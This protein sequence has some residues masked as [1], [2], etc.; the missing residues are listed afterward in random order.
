VSF[1]K[2]IVHLKLLSIFSKK[3][4]INL[5]IESP[6]M[7]LNENLFKK[8]KSKK[9][10]QF[11]IEQIK[12]KNGK[13]SFS[14]N[15]V[16]FRINNLNL[17][18]VRNKDK[19]V[20]YLKAPFLE[21]TLPIEKEYVK[22]H[23]RLSGKLFQQ[24]E[25]I[26][27][28][29][30]YWKTDNFNIKLS[31]NMS[32]KKDIALTAIFSGNPE[33]ILY[34]L[35]KDFNIS[36]FLS[37]RI[38]IIKHYKKKLN[39]K[40]IFKSK[41]FHI[42][43]EN[44]TDLKGQGEWNNKDKKI[45]LKAYLHSSRLRSFMTVN[46]EY[47]K[48]IIKGNNFSAK[49]ACKLISIHD[50]VPLNGIIDTGSIE[51]NKKNVSGEVLIKEYKKKNY[52]NEKEFNTDGLID[53]NYNKETKI[54]KFS[55]QRL[56]TEF[57]E[58]AINGM[59][60]SAKKSMT[61]KA[62]AKISNMSAINKYSV[63]FIDLNLS[64]WHL[65]Q[66]TGYFSL[67][68]EKSK[69]KTIFDSQFLGKDFF[70]NGTTIDSLSLNIIKKGEPI[71]GTILIKDRKL[72]TK[73]NII[74]NK[75]KTNINFLNVKGKSEK[76]FK[77]LNIP[78]PTAGE[79]YGT[80]TYSQLNGGKQPFVK[81]HLN[82]KKLYLST[83]QFN[84]VSCDFESDVDSLKLNNIDFVFK[85]GKGKAN[86]FFDF[87][88]LEYEI[89]GK[90]S[91]VNLNKIYNEITGKGEIYFDG[92]GKF[93]INPIIV[94]YRF[95]N[96]SF[97]HNR[98]FSFEGQ[99][100]VFTNFEDFSLTTSGKIHNTNHKSNFL[101]ELKKHQEQYSGNYNFNL[102]DIDLLIPWE[103]NIGVIAI[104]GYFNSNAKNK[105]INTGIANFSGK[106]LVLPSFSHAIENY[107][108]FI[109]FDNNNFTLESLKG[110]IG[111]GAV[112]LNGNVH[113]NDDGIQNAQL[114]LTGSRMLIFPMN[115]TQFNMDADISLKYNNKGLSLSGNMNI[116]SGI[117]ER[118]T[119]EGISFYTS[120]NFSPE[121]AD[122]IKNMK[123]N[124]KLTGKK[125]IQMNNSFGSVTG[126]FDLSI[127]GTPDSPVIL[128]AIEG[129]TGE[130]YFS[131]SKFKLLK[132]KI[133]FNNKLENNPEIII[134]SEAFI[135]NYRIK[136][137][138]NGTS[139]SPILEFKS[140]PSL[141][142]QEIFALI[143]LGELFEKQKSIEFSSQIGSTYLLSNALMDKIQKRAKK[144]GIDL[145]RIDTR[146]SEFTTDNSPRITVGTTVL[147][148]VLIVYSTNIAG[149]RREVVYFQ[150]QLS[151]A[152]S[153]IGMRNE[154]G[155]FSVDI[156]FR[157][158][159]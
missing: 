147:K 11:N 42:G 144:F 77:I 145:L 124:L 126:G 123:L 156:R 81:G 134:K 21:I 129:K 44:F 3:K 43:Q 61:I 127:K 70:T 91:S 136:F 48:V 82:S 30:A 22:F 40:A 64:R 32:N 155:R 153:L 63:F 141:P 76:I 17:R 57:G 54:T 80:C 83:F 38:S 109:T 101:F 31:G 68:L 12:I 140:S 120:S 39:I 132:A 142:T 67:N 16:S 41:Y 69:S 106:T 102:S 107:S 4:K 73:A 2:V 46:T 5:V 135:K 104:N 97:Y 75:G 138:I 49:K 100:K 18:S 55:S 13:L 27:I 117:W 6:E 24:N 114:N 119:T 74:I 53:F 58:L 86:I 20:Y 112:E 52:I 79:I 110:T 90:A 113:I 71:T 111:G 72:E 121:K 99:A 94:K 78:S 50:A 66:G 130:I 51:I 148:N 108:G 88:K 118:E 158:K 7:L 98:F 60:N 85:D 131:N 14:T 95:P 28:S 15:D 116:L 35:L 9:Q 33:T 137:N 26:E 157:K 92:K 34:P 93:L 125:N 133:L 96:S 103:N 159:D 19:I 152:I 84:D 149:L 47:G 65:K 151:P 29:S 36:G 10:T 45:G 115:R 62:N 23:G 146:L 154:A 150:Y 1:K 128:G 122:I 105:I 139:E 59:Y 143:S 56:K 87:L 89:H 25:S 8:S 37:S